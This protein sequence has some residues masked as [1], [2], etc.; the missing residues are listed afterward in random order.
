MSETKKINAKVR[1]KLRGDSAEN[2][3]NENPIL[4]LKEPCLILDESDKAIGFKIGDGVSS[5]DDLE[6]HNFN[7]NVSIEID[8]TYNPASENAQSGKA[9]A[10]AID[11]KIYYTKNTFANV[12]KGS[13]S[14]ESITVDDVSPIEHSLDISVKSRNLNHFFKPQARAGLTFTTEDNGSTLVINGTVDVTATSS[15]TF[16]VG[17]PENNYIV[18]FIF[19]NMPEDTGN[20]YITTK[21][22]WHTVYCKSGDGV[23]SKTISGAINN[24]QFVVGT[25]SNGVTF[26]NTKI[27]C[28]IGLA[29]EIT[30]PEVFTP[31]VPDVSTVSISISGESIEQTVTANAD[32][33][34]EGLKSVSPNMTV[35]TDT[36]GVTINLEYNRDI[37]KA[38]AK[39]EQAILNNA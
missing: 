27:K 1:Y 30:Q 24:M 26:E 33:T 17:L 16:T 34:V 6:E 8:Q 38:F 19:E 39:L 29:D 37:N 20:G 2:L 21:N 32:G 3:Q 31:Y 35:S 11:E 15:T 5:W 4:A 12:L 14:G 10:E 25:T 7:E 18:T 9:V 36:E 22:I 23:Y 13:K 28:L